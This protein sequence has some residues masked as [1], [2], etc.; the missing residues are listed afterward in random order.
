MTFT[1]KIPRICESNL[2][3]LLCRVTKKSLSTLRNFL[4]IFSK[5]RQELFIQYITD[6]W[7]NRLY[8]TTKNQPQYQS[9]NYSQSIFCLPHWS[10]ISD[11]CDVCI[12]WVSVVRALHLY[13]Q[14]NSFW[15]YL[16]ALIW[17]QI[18]KKHY[19]WLLNPN[20]LWSGHMQMQRF[21]TNSFLQILF[22]SFDF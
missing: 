19:L 5:I 7:G 1:N 8:C 16:S 15:L 11:F 14:A 6:W 10:K 17:V 2:H 3:K 21:E 4:F 22:Y 13:F 9:F 18:F 20:R 12:H